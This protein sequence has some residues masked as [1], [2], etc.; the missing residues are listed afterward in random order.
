VVQTAPFYLEV[1]PAAINKGVGLHAACE[2]VG[3]RPEQAVAFGDSEN[4]IE[5]LATAGMG[6]AMGNANAAVKAALGGAAPP[7]PPP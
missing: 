5:M 4:D 3:L 7:P 6:V 2:A 1:I